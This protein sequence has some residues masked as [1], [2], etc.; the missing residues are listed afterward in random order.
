MGFGFC[1]VA[2]ITPNV[3][4]LGDVAKKYAELLSLLPVRKAQ[5]KL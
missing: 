1:R 3:L 4:P 2:G 5:N